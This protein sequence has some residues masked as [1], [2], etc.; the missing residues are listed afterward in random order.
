MLP[1]RDIMTGHNLFDIDD[2]TQTLG[3]IGLEMRIDAFK[4]EGN[5]QHASDDFGMPIDWHH[6]PLSSA[7]LSTSTVKK[8]RLSRMIVAGPTAWDQA[9]LGKE[10]N[11][12]GQHARVGG[13]LN[14]DNGSVS[15]ASV[16]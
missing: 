5:F 9:M 13:S 4:F 16:R 1:P 7:M 8:G 14:D 3:H 6:V 2:P 10:G 15:F 12:L 11:G